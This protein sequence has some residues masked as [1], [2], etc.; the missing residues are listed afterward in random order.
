MNPRKAKELLPKVQAQTG[1]PLDLLEDLTYFY[2]EQV[3]KTL[4]NLEDNH[5][6]VANLGT[7]HIKGD[8]VLTKL[9]DQL[10]ATKIWTTEVKTPRRIAYR[11]ETREKIEKLKGLR[12]NFFKERENRQ[13]KRKLRKDARLK[14]DMETQS[15]DTGGNYQLSGSHKGS[16]ESSRPETPPLSGVPSLGSQGGGRE[17][18]S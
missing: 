15:S 1:L 14:K 8:K 2:W 11:E 16:Q 3:H 17:G 13:H 18:N 6:M 4:N 9:I 7:F 5:V 10:E 12:D